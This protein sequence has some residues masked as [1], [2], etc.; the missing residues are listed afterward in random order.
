MPM[1]DV[2]NARDINDLKRMAFVNFNEIEKKLNMVND[3]VKDF[4]PVTEVTTR[5]G[6][7]VADFLAAGRSAGR[8]VLCVASGAAGISCSMPKY[9][10]IS[11]MIRRSM[12]AQSA[13]SDEVPTKCVRTNS[14]DWALR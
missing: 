8:Y 7:N 13:L 14:S 9:R 6:L 4:T 11:S 2:K 3:E 5:I 1:Q 12:A 10:V